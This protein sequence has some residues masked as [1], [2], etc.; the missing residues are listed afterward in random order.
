MFPVPNTHCL[1][2]LG[3]SAKGQRKFKKELDE[4]LARP[5]HKAICDS[6]PGV[7]TDAVSNLAQVFITDSGRHFRS[8]DA[9]NPDWRIEPAPNLPHDSET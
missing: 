4:Y 2:S 1:A 8:Q 9:S 3:L 5:G 7:A 6:K